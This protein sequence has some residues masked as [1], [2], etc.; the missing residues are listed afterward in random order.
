MANWTKDSVRELV[1]TAI[2]KEQERLKRHNQK[3]TP[4]YL[5]DILADTILA[6]MANARSRELQRALLVIEEGKDITSHLRERR[7]ATMMMAQALQNYAD[8]KAKERK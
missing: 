7:N 8:K 3:L 5:A 1:E 4:D 2:K 6:L